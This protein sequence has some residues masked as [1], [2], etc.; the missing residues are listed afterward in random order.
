MIPT[1]IIPVAIYAAVVST[2]VL[3]WDIIKWRQQRRLQLVGRVTS[4]MVLQGGGI[5][6]HNLEKSYISLQ[7]D[8]RGQVACEVQSVVLLAYTNLFNA[9][10]GKLYKSAVILDPMSELTQKRLPFRLE[11]GSTYWGLVEQ[12][13]EI[14]EL[15]R[16]ARVYI[17]ITHNMAKRPF[18]VRLRPIAEG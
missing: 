17:G 2:I 1:S 10:R 12:T 16:S 13:P 5:N 6:L 18:K 14:E 7:V 4:G 15:S 3:V 11:Q 9:L 8:N